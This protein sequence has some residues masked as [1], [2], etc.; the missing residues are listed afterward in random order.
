MQKIFQ[1]SQENIGGLDKKHRW[2]KSF[3]DADQEYNVQ[4]TILKEI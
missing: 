1:Q 2:W 4:D 3:N